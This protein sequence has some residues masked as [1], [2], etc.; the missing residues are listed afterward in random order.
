MQSQPLVTARFTLDKAHASHSGWKRR[1][2][3]A[4]EVS[5]VLDVDTIKRDDC[6]DLGQWI[7]SS[8]RTHYGHFP[9]FQALLEKHKEFHAI[10]GIV[11]G[12]VNDKKAD[13]AKS[14]LGGSSQFSYASMEVLVAI[15]ALRKILT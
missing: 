4:V 13:T 12:I 10:T 9:E 8:G 6:C 7:Y 1:L 5:E 15:N 2:Q 11:A 3:K 14:M